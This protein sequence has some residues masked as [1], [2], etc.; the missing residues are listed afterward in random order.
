MFRLMI[1]STL[2]GGVGAITACNKAKPPGR[3]GA[4]E[5]AKDP[6]QSSQEAADL[7]IRLSKDSPE[8]GF[9]RK[10]RIEGTATEVYLHDDVIATERDIARMA[11]MRLRSGRYAL[12]IEF[13]NSGLKKLQ[14]AIDAD[15]TIS[16]AF[17]V[18]GK[19]RMA[20]VLQGPL[21]KRVVIEGNF[22]YSELTELIDSISKF[23]PAVPAK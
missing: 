23:G 11:P 12:A 8:S 9:L 3:N 14:N 18:K 22:T 21:A 1:C 2:I 17:I 4:H 16:I 20:P 19:V 5:R 7:E 15:N 10:G 6:T 13:T